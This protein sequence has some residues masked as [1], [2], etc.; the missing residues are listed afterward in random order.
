MENFLL[1]VS[2]YLIF[3]TG[4]IIVLTETV[5]LYLPAGTGFMP[6][7]PIF[8]ELCLIM[9]GV[10]YIFDHLLTFII[11]KVSQKREL[12]ITS[13]IFMVEDTSRDIK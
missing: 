9:F 6:L 1:N 10:L 13:F 12:T 4:I 8:L 7:S 2:I 5:G 11:R 3:L